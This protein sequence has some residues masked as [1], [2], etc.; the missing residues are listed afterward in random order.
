MLFNKEEIEKLEHFKSIASTLNDYEHKFQKDPS[1]IN[2]LTSSGVDIYFYLTSFKNLILDMDSFIKI[3][4]GSHEVLFEYISLFE[5]SL[6]NNFY[7]I[8]RNIVD[9]SLYLKNFFQDLYWFLRMIVEWQRNNN[10]LSNRNRG[11]ISNLKYFQELYSK[12]ELL[13]DNN[14]EWLCCTNRRKVE[15]F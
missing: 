13:S 11:F 14:F 6:N 7:N 12:I 5:K 8:N 15:L 4:N 2:L 3:D 10:S 9:Y 1:L